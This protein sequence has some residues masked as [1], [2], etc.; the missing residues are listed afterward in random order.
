MV[1]TKAVV[2]LLG[3]LLFRVLLPRRQRRTN[4]AVTPYGSVFDV[5]I[6]A[7]LACSGLCDR[8]EIPGTEAWRSHANKRGS[9]LCWPKIEVTNHEYAAS[10]CELQQSDSS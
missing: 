10:R 3:I 7:E 2:L 8:V 9:M 1:M 5:A 4:T 6:P